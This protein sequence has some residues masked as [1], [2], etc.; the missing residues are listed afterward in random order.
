MRQFVVGG[1]VTLLL[2]SPVSA[3]SGSYSD[4]RNTNQYYRN[5]D[6]DRS[7]STKG[8]SET[9]TQGNQT[10]APNGDQPSGESRTR[11]WNYKNSSGYHWNTENSCWGKGVYRQCN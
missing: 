10:T 8:A 6:L 5:Y 1:L 7:T 4:E 2:A 9:N 11:H 3:Q